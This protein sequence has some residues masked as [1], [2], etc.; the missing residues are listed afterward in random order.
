MKTPP[1]WSLAL[2]LRGSCSSSEA[3]GAGDADLARGKSLFQSAG[4]TLCHGQNGEGGV[5]GPALQGLAAHWDAE[6]LA[7]FIADP[8]PFVKQDARLA[9]QAAK[10]PLPMAAQTSLSEG[11][12]LLLARYLLQR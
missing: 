1:P 12:R 4:C 8:S 3:P 5:A 2:L 6:R 11:D 9:Q 10:Y 7:G